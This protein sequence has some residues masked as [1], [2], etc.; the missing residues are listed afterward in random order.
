MPGAFQERVSTAMPPSYGLQQMY[1]S[2]LQSAAPPVHAPPAPQGPIRGGGPISEL[3]EFVQRDRRFPVSSHRPILKWEWDTRM[4]NAVTLE[5]RAT[6]SFIHEGIPHHASGAWQTSKKS[7][8]RDAAERVLMM[9]KGQQSIA[10]QTSQEKSCFP[11]ESLAV[12]KLSAFCAK[13]TGKVMEETLQWE[14]TQIDGGWQ[15]T[16]EARI[17]GDV[18]HTL[19]GAVCGSEQAAI[20][21]TA[22]RALWYLK[23]PG[24]T[25]AF[26]VSHEQVVNETLDVPLSETWLR[27]GMVAGADLYKS[28]TQQRAAEQKTTLMREQNRLQKRYGKDLPTGTP[29]W[30][31]QYEYSPMTEQDTLVI[32]VCRAKVRLAGPNIEF[33]GQWCRGQKQAQLNACQQVTEYL[34]AEERGDSSHCNSR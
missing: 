8:Q 15:A 22:K 13:L 34:D 25:L 10:E 12:D 21:D 1:A 5:F 31:W 7:A 23:A 9:L 26:E 3:Q 17:Y 29:V 20:E 28:E 32:P 2:P 16:V 19:Q 30:D 4:A 33:Q 6:V 27:E 24:H 18:V 11:P 14:C